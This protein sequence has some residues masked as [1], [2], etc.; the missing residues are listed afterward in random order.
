MFRAKINVMLRSAILDVQGKTVENALHSLGYMG[1]GHVRMGKHIT[2]E[3]DAPDQ[4]TAETTARE[5]CS[6]LL[7][8]PVIED[9]DLVVTAIEMEETR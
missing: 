4:A 1:I 7:S 8:N 5:V 9:F 6:R 2:L 3:I